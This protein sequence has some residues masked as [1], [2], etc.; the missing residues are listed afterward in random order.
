MSTEKLID[1]LYANRFKDWVFNP[2]DSTLNTFWQH[3]LAENP[4][5]RTEV[6]AFK[7][8]I[9]AMHQSSATPF[10]ENA[11]RELWQRIKNT[12][13]TETKIE[14]E[15][16]TPLRAFS[17]WKRW[18]VAASF[19]VIVMASYY[20]FNPKNEN[21]ECLIQTAYNQ[22]QSLKLPDGSEVTLN[23]NSSIRFPKQWKLGEDRNVTLNGEAF[24]TVNE[25][26]TTAH[27]DR[28]I[29]HTPE[30]D[31]EV[32]GTRFNVNT[33]SPKTQV[34]LQKGSVE[35]VTKQ[36]KQEKKYNLVPGQRATFDKQ[37]NV[38][39]IAPVISNAYLGWKDK[40]F[41]FEKTPLSEVAM[42]L[43]NTYGIK[44]TINDKELA[45]KQIS[46]EIPISEKKSL[47][48]ALSTLYSLKIEEKEKE[49]L[50]ISR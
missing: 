33:Y 23:S 3:W 7:N 43:E 14:E 40:K 1:I 48:L 15:S 22:T 19:L 50:I 41:I 49:V 47:F 9:L 16:V 30:L 42:M 12:L 5:E 13:E 2:T 4:S 10:D 24:F 45:A 37:A 8:L 44:V 11:E 25:Q 35:I 36:N 17:F 21:S 38:V 26:G 20:F 34:V 32:L 28:F 27:K 46:G 6:E 18:A 39:E 31:V 29:V